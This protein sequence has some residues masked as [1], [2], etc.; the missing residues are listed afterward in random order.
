MVA[1]GT[2][3]HVALVKLESVVGKGATGCVWKASSDIKGAS[4]IAL[5]QS[6]APLR[7][8]KPLIVHEAC[9]LRHLQGHVSIP[10]FYAYHRQ[11]HFEF[12]ALE[13]LGSD[14][15]HLLKYHD[16]KFVLSTVLKIADQM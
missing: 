10:K 13:L 7:L 14:L 4:F 8:K 15:T 11:E 3:A 6:R 5:K 1:N 9:I 2:A 12:L 16:G